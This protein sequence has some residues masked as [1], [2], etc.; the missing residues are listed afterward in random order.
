[1]CVYAR[2]CYNWYW[3]IMI[4]GLNKIGENGERAKLELN[5]PRLDEYFLNNQEPNVTFILSCRPIR[6]T[7]NNRTSGPVFLARFNSVVN[8]LLEQSKG[9]RHIRSKSIIGFSGKRLPVRGYP[10]HVVLVHLYTDYIWGRAGD[11]KST[12]YVVMHYQ[13]HCWVLNDLNR[14]SLPD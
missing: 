2:H 11:V 4:K 10:C 7:Q 14:L 9:T 5:W 12:L 3:S 1:M 6:H 8:T 13:G